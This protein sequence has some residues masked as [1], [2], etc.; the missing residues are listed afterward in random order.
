M[1]AAG[2]LVT[3]FATFANSGVVDAFV[4]PSQSSSCV[5]RSVTS[6]LPKS[7]SLR[8]FL[9]VVLMM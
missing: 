6:A 4:T 9:L 7:S 5:G 1:R 3:L 2:L 8:E